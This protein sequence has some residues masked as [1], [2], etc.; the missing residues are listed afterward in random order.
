MRPLAAVLLF[1]L[2]CAGAEIIGS[3][4][5]PGGALVFNA[6]FF[7]LTARAHLPGL[8]A[9]ADVTVQLIEIDASGAQVGPVLGSGKTD[10]GGVYRLSAPEG[11]TPSPRFVVRAIGRNAGLDAFVTGPRV[12]IDPATDATR[13]LVGAAA[14]NAGRSLDDVR[15]ADVMVVLPLVQH[16]VWEIDPARTATAS[17][18]A[19]ALRHAAAMDEE[20]SNIVA[21]V[22]A[23][24]EIAGRVTDTAE[25]PLLRIAIVVRDA[26]SRVVRALA[27]T[28]AEGRYRVRVPPGDYVVDAINE[29]PF[30]PAASEQGRERITVGTAAATRNFRLR[31]G[32]RVS[33]RVSAE[34]G[35]TLLTNVR[36]Q[37]RRSGRVFEVKTQDDGG[38]R[39]NLPPGSYVLSAQNTT[40]Q[41]YATRLNAQHVEIE[42]G[43]SVTAHM[44]LEAGHLVSGVVSDA[45]KGPQAGM[46][47]RVAGTELRTNRAGEYRLWVKPGAHAVEAR[48]QKVQVDATAGHTRQDLT[49][50]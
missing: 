4:G 1:P 6:P 17:G 22:A 24:G 26:G 10:T 28:D 3:V 34:S 5:A 11:F 2:A 20:V 48:G 33:G 21:S 12:N 30:S 8:Q 15:I 29:A 35:R 40:L 47:L 42:A 18:L 50:R 16:L 7:D 23:G 32:G 36:V 41:P 13:A 45:G 9:V 31:A 19:A 25:K 38:Y 37:L 44:S 27:Y 14:A 39:L 46:P 49:L 43:A